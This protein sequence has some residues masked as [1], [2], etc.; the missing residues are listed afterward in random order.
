MD[1]R[2]FE[3]VALRVLGVLGIISSI[4]LFV[5]TFYIAS[6][7]KTHPVAQGTDLSYFEPWK[8]LVISGL[9]LFISFVCFHIADY[10]ERYDR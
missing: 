8:M 10:K 5:S 6:W 9:G 7:L 3:R 4:G 1:W 2:T